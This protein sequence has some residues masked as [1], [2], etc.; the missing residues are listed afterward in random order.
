M[1]IVVMFLPPNVTPLEQ[2][3]DQNVNQAV[4]LHY[5]KGL[6]KRII[7]SEGAD[8]SAELNLVNLKGVIGLVK[9]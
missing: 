6:L 8:I 1:K 5:K 4:K 9:A 3:I 7:A 2:P